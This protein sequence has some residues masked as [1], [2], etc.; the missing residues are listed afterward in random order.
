M[1]SLSLFYMI[2]ISLTTFIGFRPCL[3]ALISP[4]QY[5]VWVKPTSEMSFLYGN[6]IP[7]SGL[8]RM[9][10]DTPQYAGVVVYNMSDVALGTYKIQARPL[11]CYSVCL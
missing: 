5:K 9:T 3:V 1:A 6:H 2:S 11:L 4:G 7:K 8:G 10:D